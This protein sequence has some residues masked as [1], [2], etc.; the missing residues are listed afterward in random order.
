MAC[1]SVGRKD[2]VLLPR[3]LLKIPFAAPIENK[4]TTQTTIGLAFPDPLAMSQ[5]AL[6]IARKAYKRLPEIGFNGC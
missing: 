4:H 3:V 2:K 5:R 1:G 6:M